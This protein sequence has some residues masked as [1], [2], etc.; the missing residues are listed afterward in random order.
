MKSILQQKDQ[1]EYHVPSAN[2]S[3]YTMHQLHLS[4]YSRYI[5]SKNTNSNKSK[6]ATNK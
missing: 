3:Q 1:S 4:Y 5:I 6:K 2:P